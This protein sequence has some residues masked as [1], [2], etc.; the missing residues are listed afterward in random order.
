MSSVSSKNSEALATQVPAPRSK[1]PL[2]GPSIRDFVGALGCVA[3]AT[4]V[5]IGLTPYIS[6]TGAWVFFFPAIAWASWTWGFWPGCLSLVTSAFAAIW[7]FVPPEYSLGIR[8]N[9]DYVMLWAFLVSGFVVVVLGSA[10]S[11]TRIRLE[12]ES[13]DREQ[14]QAD[15]AQSL[16][17]FRGVFD[18]ARG[19][20][21]ILMS[22]ERR[23]EAWNAGAETLFGWRAPDAIGQRIEFVVADSGVL[24]ADFIGDFE[25]ADEGESAYNERMYRTSEGRRVWGQSVTTV[26]RSAFGGSSGYLMIVRDGTARRHFEQVMQSQN[27]QLERLV[28]GRTA[29]LLAANAE[30]EGFTYSV[31]HDMR[32]PLRG[33][34]GNSRMLIEDYAS[35]LD[36]DGQLRLSRLAASAMKLNGLVEDLLTYARLGKQPPTGEHCD[37]SELFRE[38]VADEVCDDDAE[39]VCMSGLEAVCDP[40]LIRMVMDNL[41][42]NAVKYK[43]TDAPLRIEFGAERQSD[44]TTYFVRDNGIGFDMDYKEKLFKPFERLHRDDQYPGTGIGLANVR[45]IIERHGGKVWAE[46]H[47]GAGSTFWFTLGGP[48]P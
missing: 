24:G 25:R 10:H 41:V 43:R 9:S 34:V 36:S 46:G 6:T 32:A 39:I 8:S 16:Q 18:N 11:R 19:D 48:E 3:L 45:R 47:P 12:Q 2:A 31:S 27:E 40:G 28:E 1:E 14:A 42:S 13:V 30:L 20:A 26:L 23:I 38:V 22:P 4:I 37:L 17:L 5:R 33:I 15:L 44:T 21:M 29:E 7:F 35:V